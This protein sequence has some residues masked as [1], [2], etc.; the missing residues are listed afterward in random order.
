MIERKPV[1]PRSI[2]HRHILAG[3][4]GKIVPLPLTTTTPL[5]LLLM[6][7]LE[8]LTMNRWIAVLWLAG[9]STLGAA[10]EPTPELSADDLVA[11]AQQFLVDDARRDFPDAD[12]RVNVNPLD[13][14]LRFSA[15][16]KLALTPHGARG[17]GRTSVTVRCDQPQP[18]AASLTATIEVWRRVV[19]AVHALPSD[20]V[21][22][23]DDV[24]LQ[25]RD[26]G[27]LHD[28]YLAEPDRAIGW[29]VRRP[30]AAGTVLSARQL[31]APIA[32]NKGDEVR[33]SAGSGS[34][35]VSMNGTALGNGMPGEQIAVRNI[36]SDRI[37]RAWVVGPGLV[38]TGPRRP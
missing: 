33:I 6:N 17:Y 8:R 16:D 9:A 28:Q 25:P 13:A 20:A 14:R 34:I 3:A 5:R 22:R 32:V 12:V 10:A 37:V 27:E 4:D 1:A 35:A 2:A 18:W 11:K 30:I 21:I 7:E 15:C 36:Q 38:S 31:V 19:I 26:I 23:T 24:A 29:T